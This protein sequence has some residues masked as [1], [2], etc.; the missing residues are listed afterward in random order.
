M[1][2]EGR[3]F[4]GLSVRDV[5]YVIK[6]VNKH[7]IKGPV[8]TLGNQDIYATSEQ[9][10]KWMED[11]NCKPSVPSSIEYSTSAST[12]KVNEE[13][14]RYI[15]A[16]TFFEMLGIPA[17]QYY[18]ID[19]F[20]FDKPKILFDMQ[21]EVDE[22]LSNSFNFIIDSGTLEHI[23]DIKQVLSNIVKMTK[24]NGY[25][26][27]IIP[28]HNFVNHGFYQCS[29]TLLDDFYKAS[30]FEIA[31]SH[32]VEIKQFYSRFYKYNQEQDYLGMYLSPGKRY[33]SVF[34]VQK[35]IEQAK[36]VNPDQYLYSM[37]VKKPDSVRETFNKTFIDKLTSFLRKIVPIK[38]H[39]VFFGIWQM[40]KRLE[41]KR[42]YFDIG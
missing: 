9:V 16:K 14:K 26:L 31:E 11:Y 13:A 17:D 38:L 25:V 34:L 3:I 8:L 40:M 39:G 2:L 30:G 33:V 20:D 4:M 19:K 12:V 22:K 37:L 23:F 32:V 35:I 41:D 6:T 42:E 7:K 24:L 5:K 18:D 1:V 10:I 21:D 28:T 27:H 29:P 36:I 15:H